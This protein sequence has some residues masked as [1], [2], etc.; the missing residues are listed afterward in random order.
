MAQSKHVGKVV[1][2]LSDQPV[3]AVAAPGGRSMIRP[4]ATYVVTGG[5][6]GF[7]LEISKWL[8]SR[9][10]RHLV[11]MSRSGMADDETKQA[12]MVMQSEGVEV[13]A[14]PVDV[15]D[16]DQLRP[17]FE[18][19]TATMPP[20]RGVIH[21]AMVL[22]DSLLSGLTADRLRNVMAPKILGALNLD[23]AT[24]DIPLDFFVML[25]SVSALVGNVGQ[26]SYGAANAF[27]DGFAHYRRSRGL[28]AIAINWG[29]L[30]EVGVAA[31]NPQA[32]KIINAAGVHSLHV[33]HALY[34]LEQALTLNLPQVGI[35]HVDWRRWRATHPDRATAALFESLFAQHDESSDSAGLD[36]RQQ[37]LHRLL[38]LDPQARMD[39]MQILLAEELARVVQMPASQIDVHQ[40]VMTLGVDSLMAVELQTALQ[41]KFALQL[42]AMELTRGLSVAQLAA[43]LLGSIAA[44]V[45][46]LSAA[47]V[48]SEQALDS[49]LRAEMAGVSAAEV[50]QMVKEAVAGK[51]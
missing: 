34:A 37:L 45:D 23:S 32:E 25:S 44:D 24:R 8:A 17:I 5:T 39:Y 18:R 47:G 7:G 51:E 43:R 28:P 26:G 13:V 29:A 35:F 31:R 10:A 50:E 48:V 15:A 30:A 27:L 6:R 2:D 20:L 16:A 1:L 38:V 14:E 46:A 4:D 42:S 36:P 22:D 21:G 40:N 3:M 49:L 11:L 41:G 33:D 9:G 12:V 19:I